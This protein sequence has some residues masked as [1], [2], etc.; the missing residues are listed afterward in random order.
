MRQVWRVLPNRDRKGASAFNMF[1]RDIRDGVCLKLLEDRHAPAVFGVVNRE[2]AHLRKWL[3]W[4]DDTTNVGYTL[5]FIKTSLQQFANNEGLTAGIWSGNEYAG[6]IGT[7]KINWLN[8]KV[9]IGYWIAA[10]FQ[11]KGI[12]T[13]AC[14]AL[15]EHAFEEWKLNRV[16]IHCATGN[17]KSCAI[18]ERLGFQLE[19]VLQKA[20]FVHGKYLDSNVYG[21]LARDWKR[22]LK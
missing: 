2:R 6:T 13:D 1:Q 17:K 4:V 10:K 8:R 9:E 19:G 16:E 21:M 18:P 20:L 15:M 3:P 7:H 5:S 22:A 11:G 12:V 14:R